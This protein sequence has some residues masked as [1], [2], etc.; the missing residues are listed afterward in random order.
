MKAA[1]CRDRQHRQ[2]T[3]HTRNQLSWAS[4]K[5]VLI[6]AKA[7]GAQF[8]I[9]ATANAPTRLIGSALICW[10]VAAQR[11]RCSD[12]YPRMRSPALANA[13]RCIHL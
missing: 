8:E 3:M 1:G 7:S 4:D 13:F 10:T 5:H 9:G 12:P 11:A 2:C 6:E